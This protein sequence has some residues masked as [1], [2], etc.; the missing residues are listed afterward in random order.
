MSQ[1]FYRDPGSFFIK[2][3]KKYIQLKKEKVTRLLT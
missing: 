2:F 1:I 3:G